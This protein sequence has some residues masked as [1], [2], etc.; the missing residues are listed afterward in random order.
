MFLLDCGDLSWGFLPPPP[1]PA[2]TLA[3][4]TWLHV[5]SSLLFRGPACGSPAKG[6][7]KT[8]ALG[9]QDDKLLFL[10]SP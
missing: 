1:I 7:G 8:V 4:P 10:F 3:P 6:P 2:P 5:R 9:F